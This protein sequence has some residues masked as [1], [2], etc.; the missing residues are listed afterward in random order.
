MWRIYIRSPILS[1]YNQCS[2]NECLVLIRHSYSSVQFVFV[3]ISHIFNFI[4]CYG[5]YFDLIRYIELQCLIRF[6]FILLEIKIKIQYYVCSILHLPEFEFALFFILSS[7]KASPLFTITTVDDGL[8]INIFD[9]LITH[10]S[11]VSF[12]SLSS[13]DIQT[14]SFVF[15]PFGGWQ[16]D[17]GPLGG[18]PAL[19]TTTATTLTN[20][21]TTMTTP[22]TTIT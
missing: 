6:Y 9:N 14:P 16:S 7:F 21:A 2:E 1:T 19:K 11:D 12:G 10:G 17:S 20:T 8:F 13:F 3:S 18:L 15:L 5:V 22:M 4:Y